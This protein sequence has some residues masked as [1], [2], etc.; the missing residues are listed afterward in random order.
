[1]TTKLNMDGIKMEIAEAQRDRI[2]AETDK[3]AG[4]LTRIEADTV[5]LRIQ[6]EV[7]ME[8]L[9]TAMIVAS[10]NLRNEQAT[11]ANDVFH[12]LF[13]FNTVVDAKTVQECVDRLAYWH[14]TA[15]E[16]D[17]E[18]VFTSPGGDMLYGLALFDYINV[19]RRQ[20]HKVI[21]GTLGIAASMAGVL[22]QAGDVRYMGK[23]AWLLLHEGQMG[24]SGKVADVE[25]ALAWNNRIR[26]RMVELILSRCREADPTTALSGLSKKK[27]MDGI[28]RKDWMI[29]SDEALTFGIIDEIR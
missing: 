9:K 3:M 19:I 25:D 8:S 15:P 20:G 11:L 5:S 18:I 22:L 4:E 6:A 28:K 26:G 12:H 24:V 17:I 7:N 13:Q 27:L 23:E 14:R 1:M 10:T 29:S 16:C 2:R 21:T